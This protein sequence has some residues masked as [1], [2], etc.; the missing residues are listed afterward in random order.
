[1]RTT[2]TPKATKPAATPLRSVALPQFIHAPSAE[3]ASAE[4][5]VLRERVATTAKLHERTIG[6]LVGIVF[7]ADMHGTGAIALAVGALATIAEEL[8]LLNIAMSD[9][10]EPADKYSDDVYRIMRRAKVA[11]ELADRIE[12]ASKAVAS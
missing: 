4:R 7:G 12:H 1:M 10:S 11:V 5:V 3:D 2:T 6:E 8:D 9:S